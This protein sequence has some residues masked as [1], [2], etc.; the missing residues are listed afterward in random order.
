MPST[1]GEAFPC[2][3]IHMPTV[4]P[5]FWTISNGVWD[6]SEIETQVLLVLFHGFVVFLSRKSVVKEDSIVGSVYL[7]IEAYLQHIS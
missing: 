6:L 3:P 1:P 7:L 4:L 2:L 5:Q